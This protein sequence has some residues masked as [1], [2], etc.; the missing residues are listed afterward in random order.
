MV[1]ITFV[2]HDADFDRLEA[3]RQQTAADLTGNEAARQLL[4]QELRR[5]HP[6]RPVFDDNG[7]LI[8]QEG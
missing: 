1:Q 8:E 6:A 7:R 2:L 4:E 5:Q 3:I